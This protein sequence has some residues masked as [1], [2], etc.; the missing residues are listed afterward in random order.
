MAKLQDLPP[1]LQKQV[2]PGLMA[3]HRALRKETPEAATARGKKA[4]QTRL[5]K[6][7]R[8]AK[9]LAASNNNSK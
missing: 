5:D 2:M 6:A 7:R 4:W 1:E 3:A 9:E 8:K